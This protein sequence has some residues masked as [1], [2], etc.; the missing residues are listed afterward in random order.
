VSGAPR[1][2]YISSWAK[3]KPAITSSSA[4]RPN[5]MLATLAERSSVAKAL[6][7]LDR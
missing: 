3:R 1:A 2:G 5:G 7:I 4:G 6:A